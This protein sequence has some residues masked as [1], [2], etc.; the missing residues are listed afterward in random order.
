MLSSISLV[1]PALLE[2]LSSFIFKEVRKFLLLLSKKLVNEVLFE[3]KLYTKYNTKDAIQQITERYKS[4][5]EEINAA[6]GLNIS[7]T[8]FAVY[9]YFALPASDSLEIPLIGFSVSRKMWISIAPLIS[10]T[11]QT[12]ILTSFIWFLGLRLSIKIIRARLENN[13]Q[14]EDI[15]SSGKNI[16]STLVETSSNWPD[17]TNLFLKGIIGNLWMLFRIGES[18]RFRYNY[19]WY[20]PLFFLILLVFI[21][22]V[23]VCIYF[24]IQLFGMKM[25]LI[26]IIYTVFLF[27]YLLLFFMLISIVALLS[28]S[29]R[30]Y[31]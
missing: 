19:F 21:S 23:L 15:E 25:F 28:A 13:I 16:V 24:I 3:G 26:A 7:F 6:L 8:F 18:L 14:I 22:P 5:V 10:Y 17:F 27:P 4:S 1:L 29:E 2:I 30:L 9:A 11:F 20:Y 31:G 12:F